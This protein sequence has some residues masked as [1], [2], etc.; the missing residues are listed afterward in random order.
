MPDSPALDSRALLGLLAKAHQIFAG[1]GVS[2]SFPLGAPVSFDATAFTDATG[3]APDASGHA[4][5]A[6]FSTMMNWIPDGPVWPPTE[7]RTLDDVVRYVVEQGTWAVGALTADEEARVTRNKALVDMANPVMQE[8]CARKDAWIRSREQ[9]R[10]KPEDALAAEAEKRAEVA[11]VTCPGRQEIEQALHDLVALDDKA[12]YRAREEMQRLIDV[13]NG[14]FDDPSGGRFSPVR[15][16]PREVLLAPQWDSV[17]L[18]HES[19]EALAAGAPPEL[20]GHLS[21]GSSDENPIVSISFEYASARLHRPWLDE[22]LFQLRCW[23]FDQPDRLLSDGA[24]PPAGD[25][26]SYVRAVVL[27]RNVSVTTQRPAGEATPPAPAIDFL[28]PHEGRLQLTKKMLRRSRLRTD[29]AY[30]A[31]LAEMLASAPQPTVEAAAPAIEV[32]A[33]QEF[34]QVAEVS[35]FAAIRAF[36][37]AEVAEAAIEPSVIAALNPAVVEAVAARPDEPVLLHQNLSVQLVQEASAAPDFHYTFIPVE[38]VAPE[39]S[40]APDPGLVTVSTPS[41]HLMVLALICTSITKA[42]DPDPTYSWP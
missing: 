5:L 40:P 3:P 32:A 22:R 6:E 7:P 29:E 11:L 33:A 39:P 37:T 27:V 28:V 24:D 36:S 34:T 20:V 17:T 1:D 41:G 18:D 15:P 13:G 9:A 30:A 21:A 35:R 14:T 16:L 26:P 25:C 8:Y 19:L 2:L 12:P 31:P 38:Q 4:L 23:R 42:P 10:N